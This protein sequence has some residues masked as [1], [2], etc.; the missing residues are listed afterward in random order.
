MATSP[1]PSEFRAGDTVEWTKDDLTADYPA[2]DGWSLTYHLRNA[3]SKIDFAG[4]ANGDVF[5]VTLESSATATYAAGTYR[6]IGRVN[7][8]A[9][10][11]TVWTG[12]IV[13]LADLGEDVFID[14]RRHAEKVLDA[15]E[16]VIEGRATKDQ[17]SYTI[18]NRS[19][20]RIPMKELIE[21]REFYRTEVARLKREERLK[22]GL[23][24]GTKV[25]TRFS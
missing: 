5:D 24:S 16:L 6:A 22:Q 8:G 25:L 9:V 11:K 1:E 14:D 15:I 17:Q 3:T 4:V 21:F 12:T 19:L 13:I 7:K 2:S 20:S 23:G 18:G 10:L